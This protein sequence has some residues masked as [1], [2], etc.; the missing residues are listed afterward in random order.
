MEL[1]QSFDGFNSELR[2]LLRDA[3]AREERDAMALGELEAQKQGA[4]KR[5]GEIES[6]IKKAVDE[7]QVSPVRSPAF[8]RSFRL[9]VGKDLAASVFQER[10]LAR[11]PDTIRVEG[12]ADPEAVIA[13]TYKTVSDQ[14]APDDFYTRVAFND[15]AQGV[16]AGFRQR[17]NA[18]RTKVPKLPSSLRPPLKTTL[19]RSVRP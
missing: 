4:A 18:W 3:A 11:L 5:M 17:N 6:V 15:V 8:Q 2:N 14:I 13:E 19:P 12:R 16:M 9:R 1:A 10:L 7:G